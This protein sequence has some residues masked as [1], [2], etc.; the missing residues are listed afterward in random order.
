MHCVGWHLLDMLTFDRYIGRPTCLPA[1]TGIIAGCVSGQGVNQAF[2]DAVILAQ[3][4]KYGGLT[5]ASLRAFESQCI[6][7][8]QEIMAA[9]MV[10]TASS[11]RPTCSSL[12]S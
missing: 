9:E 11:A 7:R 8:L 5:E 6:P 2:E 1:W 3:T 4:I 12:L 10:S